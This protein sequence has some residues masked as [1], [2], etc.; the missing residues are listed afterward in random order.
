[1]TDPLMSALDTIKR[2]QDYSRTLKRDDEARSHIGH[3]L[4]VVYAMRG[5]AAED[6][7]FLAAMQADIEALKK[8]NDELSKEEG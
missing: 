4:E 8:R 3:L 1:M 7:R 6:A 5:T 2:A